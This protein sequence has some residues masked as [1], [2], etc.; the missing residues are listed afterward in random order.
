M[1]AM[2][3]TYI[4]MALGFVYFCAVVDWFSQKVLS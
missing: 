4:P 2:D 3:L 1:W